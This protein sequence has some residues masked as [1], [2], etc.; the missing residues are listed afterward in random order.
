MD[1]R[2]K[3]RNGYQQTERYVDAQTEKGG[4]KAEICEEKKEESLFD[5]INQKEFART[6]Q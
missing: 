5:F 2:K 3:D 1:E 6:Q 4:C